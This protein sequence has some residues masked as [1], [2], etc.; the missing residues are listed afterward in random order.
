MRTIMRTVFQTCASWNGVPPYFLIFTNDSS[1]K[2][3]STIILDLTF[4]IWK[5][6]TSQWG[7]NLF[8][9]WEVTFP[10]T[11]SSPTACNFPGN[12]TNVNKCLS[13][14]LWMREKKDNR[15]WVMRITLKWYFLVAKQCTRKFVPMLCM[16]SHFP[17][18][19]AIFL[20]IDI[21]YR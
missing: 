20:T 7:S 15:C 19:F 18:L 6:A 8:S 9:E 10:W 5:Y 13:A 21:C 3:G 17:N 2:F 1:V 16:L 11:C 4:A 12:A 14:F